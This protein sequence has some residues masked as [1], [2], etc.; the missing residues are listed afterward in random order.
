MVSIL[1]PVYNEFVSKLVEALLTQLNAL[2]VSGEILLYDDCSLDIYKQENRKLTDLAPCIR[3]QELPQNIGRSAIRN[4]LFKDAEYDFCIVLDCDSELLDAHF[5]QRYL[6]CKNHP[7]IYGGRTYQSKPPEDETKMLR[8]KYGI[9]REQ[10]DFR[11]RAKQPYRFFLTNNFALHK[12][13][14]LKVQFDLKVDGY[15]HEDTLFSRDLER[16]SI[17]VFHIDNPVNHIGLES[18]RVFLD[19][20][21]TALKNLLMLHKAQ[22]IQSDSVALLNAYKKIERMGLLHIW[23][24]IGNVFLPIWEKNLNTANPKLMFFDLYRLYWLCKLAAKSS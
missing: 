7:V 21:V 4:L 11:E 8:W 1:I 13:V 22:R 3:Y 19:K 6:H 14:F 12:E 18:N 23:L 15:G 5:I 24:R 20:S 2:D 17:P 16:N 9:E 10:V